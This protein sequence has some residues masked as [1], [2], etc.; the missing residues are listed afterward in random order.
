MTEK[1]LKRHILIFMF[2]SKILVVLLIL[3]HWDTHGFSQSEAV[4]TFALVLPLFTV[5]LTAMIKDAITNPY[6]E[7][8]D[9]S[10]QNRTVKSSFITLT[11]ISF[12]L[13]L[14]VIL[15]VITLKPRG[16]FVF[17]DLQTAIAGVESIFGVYIGQI[18]FSLFKKEEPKKASDK[19]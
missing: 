15:Y 1:K 13:Y 8:S 10:E 14:I 19:T 18:V 6:K 11:Y 2:I 9:N 7:S 16:I 4:A 5:Y 17:S 12:P 3:F